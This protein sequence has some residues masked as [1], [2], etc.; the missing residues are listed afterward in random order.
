MKFQ[1]KGN[2]REDED[3]VELSLEYSGN[4]VTV[5]GKRLPTGI[6]WS[7]V[8]FQKD[9]TVFRHSAVGRDIGLDLTERGC[10]DFTDD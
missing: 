5:M 8:T 4:G 6:P 10:V 3:T 2:P 1:I 7:L 9:G